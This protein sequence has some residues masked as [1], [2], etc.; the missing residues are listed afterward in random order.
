MCLS[1]ALGWQ[2]VP[3]DCFDGNQRRSIALV[4]SRA[5][6]SVNR[7][8][9]V[10]VLHGLGMPPIRGKTCGNVFAERQRRESFDRHLVVVVKIDQVTQLQVSSKGG[11]LA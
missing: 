8:H 11:S 3:D 10:P 6:R 2:A 5:H 9:I 4:L 7:S 1:S